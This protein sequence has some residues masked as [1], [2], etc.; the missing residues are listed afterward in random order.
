MTTNQFNIPIVFIIFN[1]PD[2]TRQVFSE[3][4]KVKPSK[5]LV[6]ADGP[7]QG[8]TGESER[9]YE[10]REI[11]NQIDWDCEVI[12]NYSDINL[13]CKIRVSSGLDWVFQQVEEAII[14]EDDCVPD[15][16]FFAYCEQM[17]DRYR[18]DRRIFAISGDN[19]QFGNRRDQYSYYYS[20]YNHI[21]GWATWKRAWEHYDVAMN[22]WPEIRNGGWLNDILGNNR[23]AAY[24]RSIFDAVHSGKIDTWDYQ[25]TFASWLQNG[26]VV[27]PN[28]N[29]V[30]N[31]GFGAMATHTRSSESRFANMSIEPM[32][33]PMAHPPYVIR[34]AV[35]DEQTEKIMYFQSYFKIAAKFVYQ[36]YF[37][38]LIAFL[39]AVPMRH[40]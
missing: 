26:L 14:L 13:G 18:N 2:T 3:I 29:L 19:F 7:R 23:Q 10:T 37:R 4:A 12:K 33:F 38:P 9:C 25:L 31:I 16:T 11:L 39:K 22:A 35:A 5:L 32:C 28:I 40:E 6:I 30:S 24:W 21:W 17:L 8:R 1:R 36:H 34:N 27:L 20:R 15:K